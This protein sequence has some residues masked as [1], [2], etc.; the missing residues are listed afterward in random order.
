MTTT[1]PAPQFSDT[2]PDAGWSDQAIP[3]LGLTPPEPVDQ[4][5]PE[6]D[7]AGAGTVAPVDPDAPWGRF[8]NGKAKK[9][10]RGSAPP[11]RRVPA[12]PRKTTAAAKKVTPEVA[13]Y[14]LLSLGAV[15]EITGLGAV[16]A[17]MMKSKPLLADVVTLDMFAENIAQVSADYAADEPRWARVLERFTAVS[18]WSAPVSLGL[19]L[20]AQGAVNHGML[21][22]GIMGS[23][24]PDELLALAEK[25]A[26]AAKAAADQAAIRNAA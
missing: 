17:K 5:P 24:P 7:P 6:D 16:A 20:F 3:E 11:R 14:E 4:G 10:P 26:A 2:D 15:R 8:K 9:K 1:I 12:A 23:R 25:R 19:A 18:K 22:A 13:D 21:P